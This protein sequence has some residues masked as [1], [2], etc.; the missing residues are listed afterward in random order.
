MSV[1]L[2]Y[3]PVFLEHVM[4]DCPERPDRLLAIIAH[5]QETGLLAHLQILPGRAASREELLS[6][7]TPALVDMIEELAANGGGEFDG[8]T[9]VSAGS[10]R[11]A[12]YAAGSAISAVEA[13]CQSSFRQVY[14]LGR[15]PGHHATARRAM[16]FC[17]FNNV[18]IAARTAL[19]QGWVK[20]LA[21][22][23]FD[24]HH[25]NGTANSFA[26][27]P[28]VLYTSVHQWPLY[29]GTGD[30]R[31]TGIGAGRG[32]TLNIPL[33][34]HTGDAGYLRVFDELIKPALY[35]FAPELVLVSAG[36][37]AHWADPLGDM[38][39][40]AAAY[41]ELCAMISD[42]ADTLCAGRQVY[43]LEGGYH[44]G[45]LASGVAA[46]ISALLG[47]PYRDTLGP[48]SL[49]ETD[50]GDLPRRVARWHQLVN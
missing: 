38:L 12:A 46:T 48:S 32:C 8:D 35:R 30:W 14:V 16:G 43:C 7:H 11:A 13:V 36:Y 45:S 39:L 6:N 26:E 22:I 19:R 10:F 31:E 27:E 29:P 24:V 4:Y 2:I 1:G 44:L 47:L 3:D 42:W 34:P 21:I 5:L 17:L 40:S 15:P 23:D 20:K 49:K 50:I 33:P 18:A 41:R 25:G 9:F 37:D 28:R